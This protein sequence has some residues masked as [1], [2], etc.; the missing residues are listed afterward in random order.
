MWKGDYASVTVQ[1]Y[2]AEGTQFWFNS[3][4]A[5]RGPDFTVVSDRDLLAYDPM[6][7]AVLAEVYS[8]T[9]RIAADAFFGHPARLD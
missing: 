3:N 4:K 9:H 6:L 2:W 1:E 8:T 5:L 7:F